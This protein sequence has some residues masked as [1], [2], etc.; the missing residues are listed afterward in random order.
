[1]LWVLLGNRRRVSGTVTM[2]LTSRPEAVRCPR[3]TCRAPAGIA[4]VTATGYQRPPHHDRITQAAGKAPAG[5]KPAGSLTGRRPT[6]AQQRILAQAV[7]N[8]GGYE[9]S[10]YRFHGD[11][12]RRAAMGAMVD[13]ARGWFVRREVTAD[14]TV[15]EVTDAGRAAHTRNLIDPAE[16]VGR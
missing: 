11:A 9:L 6:P 2:D 15:F 12:Q 10:G 13:E 1:M 3:V 5:L 8:G 14:G 7:N 16:T 4:C